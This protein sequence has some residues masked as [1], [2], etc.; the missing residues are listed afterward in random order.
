MI[1]EVDD[2]LWDTIAQ[3]MAVSQRIGEYKKANKMAVVQPTRFSEIMTKRLAWAEANGLSKETVKTILEA[4][5][6][7]SIRMQQ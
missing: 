2:R 6:E 7:E 4:I 5:H 3:R 1:D